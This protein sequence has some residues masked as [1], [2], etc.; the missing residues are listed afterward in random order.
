MDAS[1]WKNKSV[2]VTGHTGFKGSWLSLWLQTLG[3][4]VAGLALEPPEPPALF[5]VANVAQGMDSIIGDIRHV[6]TVQEVFSRTQ[7]EIIFHLAA[8]SL[9]KQ[10][11]QAPV[12][13]YETNVMGSLHVLEAVRHTPSVRAVVMVTTDKCYEN[14]EWYWPYR[15]N[16]AMGGYDPYSSSKGCAELLI[17]SYRRS[18]F[19]VTDCHQ[20][21]AAI[22]SARAGNV[23][24]GG[25]R[26]ANRLIPDIIKAFQG[27][28]L[29]SIRS[30]NAV[31]P[32][33]HVL[34]P[35]AGYLL[36]A[37][38]LYQ[39]GAKYAEAWNFGPYEQDAKPVHW[40]VE[41][42][43]QL[44]GEETKWEID[45]AEH[46]HEATM[47]RLDSAKAHHQLNWY[48]KWTLKEALKHIVDWHREE[49]KGNVHL[50]Q[51]CLEQIAA[52]SSTVY[53]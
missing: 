22:A 30:P 42:M 41:H 15:E 2:L 43:A 28:S 45:Q 26:A 32:W 14:R 29:L 53:Q 17:A 20:L 19:N 6:S 13:T 5:D 38:K 50:R 11:Y 16:E 40:I 21:P 51:I 1:F 31:R 7:P 37:E 48:P 34:E 24:G 36:L 49:Q 35:L 46:Q 25:D 27:N 44:W 52:Y 33:Q 39:Q 9:V 12:E 8:Q 47:L 18:F 23:I 4:K 10:S 3:A